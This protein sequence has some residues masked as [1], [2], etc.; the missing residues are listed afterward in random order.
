MLW[1]N[2]PETMLLT[3]KSRTRSLLLFRR[4]AHFARMPPEQELIACRHPSPSRIATS[5]P[6]YGIGPNH[7]SNLDSRQTTS[8]REL[9]INTSLLATRLFHK[10]SSTASR[11]PPFHFNGHHHAPSLDTGLVTPQPQF[12]RKL[13]DSAQPH[14]PIYA[15]LNPCGY[16]RAQQRLR[17]LMAI[18]L[19]GLTKSVRC[20]WLQKTSTQQCAFSHY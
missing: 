20:R 6:N 15:S 18:T 11:S 8:A 10:V 2:C 4:K 19:C 12:F 9:S 14:A 1:D 13:R 16:M 17:L 3:H 5:N 7:F